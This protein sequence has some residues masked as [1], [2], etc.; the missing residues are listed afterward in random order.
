MRPF[1]AKPRHQL[2][3]ILA[4]NLNA[5]YLV[6]AATNFHCRRLLCQRYTDEQL[7]PV[8]GHNDRHPAIGSTPL[9]RRIKMGR[10]Q[11][12]DIRLICKR[13]TSDECT[14]SCQRPHSTDFP[15]FAIQAS[16]FLISSASVLCAAPSKGGSHGAR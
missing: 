5:L 15:C 16:N 11:A 2:G 9:G 3:R 6:A 1:V 13:R 12:N 7:W 14:Y 10:M 8:D 4:P